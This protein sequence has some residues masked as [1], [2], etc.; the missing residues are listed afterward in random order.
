MRQ[1]NGQ[2][3]GLNRY[4]QSN[5]PE[6]KRIRCPL[7]A[8]FKSAKVIRFLSTAGSKVKAFLAA[9]SKDK[10]VRAKGQK[11]ITDYCF[12]PG[13][14]ALMADGSHKPNEDVRVGEQ[15]LATDPETGTTG[16]NWSPLG[17]IEIFLKA[18]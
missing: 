16:P 18:G 1:A 15:V 13:T 4:P 3:P 2:N 5:K 14:P 12:V 8:L 17:N 9:Q 6:S 7:K 11:A 10:A